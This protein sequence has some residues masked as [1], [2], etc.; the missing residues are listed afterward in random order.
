MGSRKNAPHLRVVW[1]ASEASDEALSH[2]LR[3][4]WDAYATGT[5]DAPLS[6]KLQDLL[7]LLFLYS[8]FV[9]GAGGSLEDARRRLRNAHEMVLLS[10]EGFRRSLISGE[11]SQRQLW[12]ERSNQADLICREAYDWVSHLEGLQ[13]VVDRMWSALRLPPSP[14]IE[15]RDLV[16]Q[17]VRDSGDIV[18]RF[19]GDAAES[20]RISAPMIAKW[21]AVDAKRVEPLLRDAIAES[22][23]RGRPKKGER[24]TRTA[25]PRLLAELGV[26]ASPNSLKSARSR[27]KKRGGAKEAP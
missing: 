9:A 18:A 5:S 20:A 24:R 11:P 10:L 14:T 19:G 23:R 2:Q 17:H 15:R 7:R 22:A 25:L 16:L 8:E 12:R 21:F 3:A 6:A 4:K 1:S 26:R 27:L 13:G